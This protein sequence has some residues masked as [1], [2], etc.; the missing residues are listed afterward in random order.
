MKKNV[1]FL[2]TCLTFLT[3]FSCNK[4]IDD[5]DLSGMWYNSAT[6]DYQHPGKYIE[7]IKIYEKVKLTKIEGGSY[8]ATYYGLAGLQGH[9]DLWEEYGTGIWVFTKDKLLEYSKSGRVWD[10]DLIN[11]SQNG[12]TIASDFICPGGESKYLK[13]K[14]SRIFE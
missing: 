5:Y 2:L 11:I 4:D 10:S 13:K 7:Q 12:F 9:D 8:S 1:L 14:Y 6:E 3:F